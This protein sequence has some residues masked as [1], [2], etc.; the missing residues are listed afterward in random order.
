MRL[1]FKGKNSDR[2]VWI[3]H[4]IFHLTDGRY[5]LVNRNITHYTVEDGVLDM[6]WEGCYTPRNDKRNH[7][8]GLSV[9]E[10]KD[11]EIVDISFLE[12]APKGYDLF[13]TDWRACA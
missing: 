6:T 11:A 10:F 7:D 9:A 2:D 4:M 8:Y 1:V 12:D 5:I 3:K 13:I